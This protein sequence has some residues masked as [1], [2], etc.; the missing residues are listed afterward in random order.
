MPLIVILLRYSAKN[1]KYCVHIVLTRKEMIIIINLI[2][3]FLLENHGVHQKKRKKKKVTFEIMNNESNLEKKILSPLVGFTIF[4]NTD[5]C[6]LG[7]F[8]SKSCKL[9]N[10][11]VVH[12]IVTDKNLT[13]LYN[14]TC[15]SNM[16]ELFTFVPF[17]LFLNKFSLNI[18]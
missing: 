17:K 14:S 18:C 9:K 16:S 2:S 4:L 10:V 12:V 5:V 3:L 7:T 1:H 6:P 11:N 13:K 8:W 15:L